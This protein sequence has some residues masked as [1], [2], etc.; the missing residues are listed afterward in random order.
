MP[1]SGLSQSQ[2]R[3]LVVDSDGQMRRALKIGLERSNYQVYFASNGDEALD[4]TALYA[5][6]LTILDL[7]LQSPSGME[8][9]RRLREWSKSAIIVMSFHDDES[10]KI[11]LL[12]FGADDFLVKPFGIGELLARVRAVLRRAAPEA[13]SEFPVFSCD[14]L[15]IDFS[16]RLVMLNNNEVH[17]TP[18]EYSLL[19]YLVMNADRVLTRRQLSIL[20]DGNAASYDGHTLRVHIANLRKKVEKDPEKPQYIITEPRIGYRFKAQRAQRVSAG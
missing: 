11:A 3:V 19:R 2:I 7:N 4:L 5:P 12:D 16:K 18:K 14:G 17:L 1:L 8:V 9:C 6:Q 15:V 13:V 20:F 10:E